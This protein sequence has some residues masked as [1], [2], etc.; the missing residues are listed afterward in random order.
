MQNHLAS[1]PLSIPPYLEKLNPE[2]REAAES[3]DGPVLVLAGAGTGKTRVLTT[4]I[5]HILNSRRAFPNQILSVTFT[6]KAARE[7]KERVQAL[8]DNDVGSMWIGTFSTGI[9]FVN[10]DASK[11][12]HYR[13]TSSPYSLSNKNVLSIFEDSKRNLWVGTDGGGLNLFDAKNGTFSHYLHQ[14]NNDRSIGGNYVLKIFEDSRGEIWIGT[15]GDGISVLNKEKNSFKH[16]GRTAP[17]QKS[18]I[19]FRSF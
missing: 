3:L 11:F 10:R 16:F 6:N 4:R 14:P 5:A 15:W 19:C 2:Q 12:I 18:E 1:Q 7:M 9:N 13:H 17:Q 8:L